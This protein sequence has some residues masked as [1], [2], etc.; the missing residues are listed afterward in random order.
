MGGEQ[1]EEEDDV[2]RHSRQLDVEE[3]RCHLHLGLLQGAA[4]DEEVGPGEEEAGEERILKLVL[5]QENLVRIQVIPHAVDPQEARNCEEDG[6]VD[7]KSNAQEEEGVEAEDDDGQGYRPD[8]EDPAGEEDGKESAECLDKLNLFLHRLLQLL[9]AG[10]GLLL[11]LFFLVEG[12]QLRTDLDHYQET[13]LK[14]RTTHQMVQVV[15]R[16]FKTVQRP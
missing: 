9:A 5:V 15:E 13:H 6:Q 1:V 14:E 8:V 3:A 12:E 2:G 7:D 11:L 16:L 4:E 10:L